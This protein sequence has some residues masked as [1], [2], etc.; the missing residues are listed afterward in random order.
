MVLAV[1]LAVAVAVAVAVVKATAAT[2]LSVFKWF[3]KNRLIAKGE[4]VATSTGASTV[5]KSA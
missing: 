3:E 5:L 1:V 2:L 4:D